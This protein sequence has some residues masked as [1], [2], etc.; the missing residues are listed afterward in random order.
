MV[1][2]IFVYLNLG[3]YKDGLLLLTG[4]HIKLHLHCTG[5]YWLICAWLSN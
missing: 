4:G 5:N 3:Y 2:G 1:G